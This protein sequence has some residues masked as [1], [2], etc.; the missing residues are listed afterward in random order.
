M[1]VAVASSPAPFID[2]EST[3]T[4]KPTVANRK[5]KLASLGTSPAPSDG[6]AD[7]Q[8]NVLV[9][10]DRAVI[11][12]RPRLSISRHPTF[13]PIPNSGDPCLN[14]TEGHAINRKLDNVAYRYVPAGLTEVGSA[15][16]CRTIESAPTHVRVSWEDRSPF[17]KVSQDG[18]TLGGEKG[19]RSARCNVPVQEGKW[20]MEVKILKGG[21]DGKVDNSMADGAHVRLGW[22]R[23]EAPL[24]GP[25]GMD[26]YSYG[27]RDKTGEKVTLSRTK[28]YGQPFG[29]GDIIGIYI[30]LPPRRQP[31]PHDPYDPAQVKRER[32]AI[33]FKGQEYFEILDYKPSQEMID[34][35]KVQVKAK[36]AAPPNNPRESPKKPAAGKTTPS[37]ARAPKK[38]KPQ[39]ISRPLP[40]LGSESFIAFFVNGKCQGIAYQDLY[41]YLQ[42]RQTPAQIAEKQK[43]VRHREHGPRQHAENPFDDGSLGYYPFISLYGDARVRLNPGPHF[44]FTPPN[45]IDRACLTSDTLSPQEADSKER[46]WRPLQDRYQEFM[47]QQ[48]ELD[49]IEEAD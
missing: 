25:I 24:N 9:S 5:R 14:T 11:D 33:E 23:R 26:G 29:T 45:D 12:E 22:G 34:L 43:S 7:Q 17:I 36:G 15:L 46:T 37:A 30:S 8:G 42:L 10:T 19:F 48:W 3:S 41:D 28:A 35:T 39:N 27:Y 20:Y 4:S 40:T 31:D 2:P 13:V 38:V 1:E 44:E 49:V 16:P 47:Q 32:I 18:L 21:G 6:L